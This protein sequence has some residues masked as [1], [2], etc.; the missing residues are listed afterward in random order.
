MRYVKKILLM[1][2]VCNAV[3]ADGHET[4][5]LELSFDSLDY[6]MYEFDAMHNT[7]PDS[8]VCNQIHRRL[9]QRQ[10]KAFSQQCEYHINRNDNPILDKILIIVSDTIF[11]NIPNY[12]IRYAHD[13][14][15]EYGCE[16]LIYSVNDGGTYS[17]IK[18]IITSNSTDLNGCVLIGDIIEAQYH[19]DTVTIYGRTYRP[20]TWPC[21]LYYM[22]LNGTWIYSSTENAYCQHIGSN[23]APEI[24]VGRISS[25]N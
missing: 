14:H 17:D 16:T 25:H 20:D 15:K 19:L 4:D 9:A 5:S 10:L 8:I 23:I 13:I 24:F 22:D 2:L 7:I 11:E 6:V 12:I 18:S 3:I 21:D 1:M